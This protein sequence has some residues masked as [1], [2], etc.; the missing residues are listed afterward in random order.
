MP[1]QKDALHLGSLLF[2]GLNTLSFQPP[3]V[4]RADAMTDQRPCATTYPT[5]SGIDFRGA[6]ARRDKLQTISIPLQSSPSYFYQDKL[7]FFTL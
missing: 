3:P 6:Q 5:P 1:N 2:V 4:A 7:V